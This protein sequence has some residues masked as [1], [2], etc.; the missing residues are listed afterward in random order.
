MARIVLLSHRSI[1]TELLVRRFAQQGL[2]PSL[3]VLEER[4][5][6]INY[7]SSSRLARR[8]LGDAAINRVIRLRLS[9]VAR[10]AMRWEQEVKT[11]A[12]A[13]LIQEAEA[14]GL[15]ADPVDCPVMVTESVNAPVTIQRI[16]LARPDL[17]IVFGTSI[18]KPAVIDLPAHGA[19][20]MHSSLLPYNRGSMPEFW[21]CLQADLTHA[22]VTF[23]LVNAA[24]DAGDVLEQLPADRNWPVD[25]Q[26][27]RAINLI[28]AITAYP[29]VASRWLQGRISAQPQPVIDAV[30]HRLRDL[31]VERRIEIWRK[32]T[33]ETGR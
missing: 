31:T 23:H 25:P 14:R 11:N 7:R 5:T 22:G 28:N 19:I 2:P 20:N 1:A 12:E 10:S 27:L 29:D 15:I 30:P 26:Q 17:L 24:V 9:S 18:L 6:A 8:W 3:V 13:W 4:T 16:K 32:C 21:Q 33:A